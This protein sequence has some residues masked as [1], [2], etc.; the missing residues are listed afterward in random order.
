[1]K[2][3]SWLAA[4]L[5]VFSLVAQVS[6]APLFPDVPA[7][8]WARDAVAQLA[9][10]GIVEGYPDGTFKGDRAATRYEMAMVVARMLAKS[11]QMW[12]TFATKADLEALKQLVNTL[13]DE[14]DAL[15][16]RVTNLEDNLAKLTGR[17][18]DLEKIRFYGSVDTIFVTQGFRYTGTTDPWGSLNVTAYE[19]GTATGAAAGT[20]IL[21]PGVGNTTTATVNANQ[22]WTSMPVVDYFSGR[23]LT[24]GTSFSTKGVLGTKIRVSSDISA[25]AE[26]A[27]YSFVGDNVATPYYGVTPSYFS[28]VFTSQVGLANMANNAGP[29]T[30]MTLDTV[31]FVHKPSGVKVVA[32][33]FGDTSFDSIVFNGQP[34]PN[35]GAYLGS[36]PKFL[37]N[38]GM[39]VTGSNYFLS[40]MKWEVVASK[41]A[42]DVNL[43]NTAN[44][45]Y[46]SFLTGFN[47]DWEFKG[48]DFRLNFLRAAD[49][50][51]GGTALTAGGQ[52]NPFAWQ[53]PNNFFPAT[54]ANIQQ[55]PVQAGANANGLIGPQSLFLYS[56]SVRYEFPN[57][58]KFAAEYSTGT[59]KPNFN[60]TYTQDGAAARAELAYAIF[61]NLLD[62][63]LDYVAV[64]AYYD[65]FIIPYPGV[66]GGRTALVPYGGGV[67]MTRNPEPFWYFGQFAYMHGFYQLHDSEM[68]PNNRQG[69]RFY[70][71]YKLPQGNGNIYGKVGILRQ[72]GFSATMANGGVLNNPGFVE[73]FFPGMLGNDTSEGRVDNYMLG[74]NYT[75]PTSKLGVSASFDAY[76]FRR[77]PAVG[78]TAAQSNNNN[79]QV[80]EGIGKI[81][82]SYPVNDKFTLKGGYDFAMF[83]GVYM[84]TFR[85]WDYTQNLPYLGFNYNLSENTDWSMLL[86]SYS[87]SDAVATANTNRNSGFN[88]TGTRLLTEVKIT[89]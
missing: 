47:L 82:L 66:I 78:L 65:P 8:Q 13:R 33:A 5:V 34:N 72:I 67:N 49:D 52:E 26:F 62:L 27:A 75:F 68:Y 70:A 6:A 86:Q 80:G 3:F 46:N 55:R 9:A 17:V 57:N 45:Y 89:F 83:R 16:V 31:W 39:Q 61:N 64:S 71:N 19:A 32:G 21:P 29:W 42:N 24:N 10:K 84:N 20:V 25:G 87:V 40:P 88:W 77:P 85:N 1:M 81:G 50:F 60:S 18:W 28:N 14:L 79:V 53:N 30:R 2:K 63:K 43:A 76:R 38:Y 54:V 7:Q 36:Q 12:A 23:P 37:T 41:I 58:L 48:G 56:G 35:Y 59:Y 11:E 73:P 51:F 4:I 22:T 15:G 44:L 69:F 74:V